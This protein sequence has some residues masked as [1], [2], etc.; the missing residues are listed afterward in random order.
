M[1]NVSLIMDRR[2][3]SA[4]GTVTR[5]LGMDRDPAAFSACGLA[6]GSGRVSALSGACASGLT[7][8]RLD[9]RTGSKTCR[10]LGGAGPSP[11]YLEQAHVSQWRARLAG[12]A[13]PL[14]LE[15]KGAGKEGC[16]L[17]THAN[18]HVAEFLRARRLAAWPRAHHRIAPSDNSG[19]GSQ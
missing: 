12:E 10:N 2:H 5:L 19:R 16:N 6:C 15:L 17:C 8:T 3:A 9:F 18:P 4:D 11:Q 14:L 7:R 13:R 1:I